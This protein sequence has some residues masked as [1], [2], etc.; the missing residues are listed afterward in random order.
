MGYLTVSRS[1]GELIK[2]S[3]KPGVDTDALL[4][5]LLRDGI[6]IHVGELGRNKIRLGIDTPTEILVLRD[7]LAG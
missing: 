5:H 6:T 4:Q 1:E 3:I 2:L 7:E